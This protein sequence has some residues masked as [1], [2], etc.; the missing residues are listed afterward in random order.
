MKPIIHCNKIWGKQNFSRFCAILVAEE[1][2]LGFFPHILLI[3]ALE[4][5]KEFPTLQGNSQLNRMVI[6]KEMKSEAVRDA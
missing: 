4:T 3:D 6:S 2:L 5:E 1:L